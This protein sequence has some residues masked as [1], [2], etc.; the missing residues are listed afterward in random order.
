MSLREAY[1]N[2]VALAPYKTIVPAEIRTV[3]DVV[4]NR[5]KGTFGVKS[6]YDGRCCGQNHFKTVQSPHGPFIQVSLPFAESCPR[7]Q[8]WRVY[9]SLRDGVP[10][11]T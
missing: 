3:K 1:E 6:H 2:W 5:T 4:N 7:E 10:L 8:A 11:A 9:I